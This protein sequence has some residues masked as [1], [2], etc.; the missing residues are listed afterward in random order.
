MFSIR[1][2]RSAINTGHRP[3]WAARTTIWIMS[4]SR[5]APPLSGSWQLLKADVQLGGDGRCATFD[6]L[7]RQRPAAGSEP[8]LL[9]ISMFLLSVP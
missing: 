2:V 7:G 6:R 1:S 8:Q 4:V 3:V 9:L 5:P